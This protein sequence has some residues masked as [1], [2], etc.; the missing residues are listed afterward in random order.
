[1]AKIISCRY[2]S[3]LSETLRGIAGMSD[4]EAPERD[5][6]S[7]L[8]NRIAGFI[9]SPLGV[10]ILSATAFFGFVSFLSDTAQIFSVI[11]TQPQSIVAI[12]LFAL[13]IASVPV[14]LYK[15]DKTR[16]NVAIFL[17]L[18]IGLLVATIVSWPESRKLSEWAADANG[19]CVEEFKRARS[20][21]DDMTSAA[22]DLIEASTPFVE[23]PNE[24]IENLLAAIDNPVRRMFS[25]SGGISNQHGS[26]LRRIKLLELPV[27]DFE[28]D[29]ATLWI[30]EYEEYVDNFHNLHEALTGFATSGSSEDK[31]K[32]FQDTFSYVVVLQTKKDE[33]VEHGKSIQIE[34]CF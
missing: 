17:V 22:Y 20:S 2:H 34:S 7:N 30:G 19:V 9:R 3:T 25:A 8:V 15:V 14:F 32:Y 5:Q 1:M 16:K 28:S 26:T 13:L 21:I 18:L 4:Q 11:D 12:V 33:I 23:R 31:V 10:T 24:S 27:A 29:K 6:E